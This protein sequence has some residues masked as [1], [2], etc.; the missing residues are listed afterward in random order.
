MTQRTA[1]ATRP[2][3]RAAAAAATA[4][5]HTNTRNRPRRPIEESRER[6]ARALALLQDARAGRSN[7]R[8]GRKHSIVVNSSS[9]SEKEDDDAEVSPIQE[10]RN[11]GRQRTRARGGLRKSTQLIANHRDYG[12]E[13]EQGDFIT[14]SDNG[15]SD[16]IASEG[17][18]EE[19]SSTTEDNEELS[20]PVDEDDAD[21]LKNY[22]TPRKRLCRASTNERQTG[23]TSTERGQVEVPCQMLDLLEDADVCHGQSRKMSAAE[24]IRVAQEAFTQ[25]QL[26][27]CVNDISTSAEILTDEGEPST[28]LS[29]SSDLQ[30]RLKDEQLQRREDQEE[31]EGSLASFLD[32]TCENDEKI[33]HDALF[34]TRLGGMD[35]ANDAELFTR[36]LEYRLMCIVEPT[37]CDQVKK[38]QSHRA[39][40]GQAVK[41]VE[42]A[43]TAARDA[44]HSEAWRSCSKGL[45]EAM[46][47]LPGADSEWSPMHMSN[48]GNMVY[49]WEAG[50]CDILSRCDACNRK[51]SHA[52]RVITFKGKPHPPGEDDCWEDTFGNRRLSD[53]FLNASPVYKRRRRRWGR[54]GF[55]LGFASLNDSDE[56]GDEGRDDKEE[57]DTPTPDMPFEDADLHGEMVKKDF[58]VGEH[59]SARLLLYHALFHYNRRLR[60]RLKAEVKYELA[61]KSQN[62]QVCRAPGDVADRILND[63]SLLESLYHNYLHLLRLAE[64]YQFA[65]GEDARALKRAA[66]DPHKELRLVMEELYENSDVEE[67]SIDWSSAPQSDDSLN[68]S[69]ESPDQSCDRGTQVERS[70]TPRSTKVKTVID[71]DIEDDGGLGQVE[72]E[73][74]RGKRTIDIRSF[75]GTKRN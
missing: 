25:Q 46:E 4:G 28:S 63:D 62:Q 71:D 24:R 74:R 66:K 26:A 43:V 55:Q 51:K 30:G 75:F 48:V 20:H 21:E 23:K 53:T 42:E 68:D 73:T 54:Q 13:K 16:F 57:D 52:T 37:Y 33:Q 35:R 19:N 18:E 38:S 1:T 49:D 9:T 32:K 34:E 36:F 47:W 60:A 29:G 3:T 65:G 69:L 40:Y 50:Q 44:V 56:K 64:T 61:R 10:R 7:T 31:P 6:R 27:D 5:A 59:C 11:M 45:L 12:S 41:K 70:L 17:Y 22:K 72:D 8:S 2:L 67:S 14:D 58:H 15:L 39:Y